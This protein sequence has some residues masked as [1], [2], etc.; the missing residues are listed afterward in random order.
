MGKLYLLTGDIIE[1]AEG[2]DAIVNAQNKHMANGSGICGAIYRNAGVELLEYCQRTY[3][4][5]MEPCEVRVTPGFNLNMNIIHSYAPIFSEWDNPID[6]LIEAYSNVLN[7]I[8]NH[9][10]KKVIIPSLG[11][12]IH[13]YNHEDVAHSVISLLYK[14]CERNDVD[15]YFINRFSIA[16]NEYLIALLELQT[17]DEKYI[18]A[19]LLNEEECFDQFVDGKELEDMCYYEQLIYKKVTE[20]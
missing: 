19:M 16:T 20:K 4:D 10:Y 1:N 6:K 9:D 2:M 11:T 17:F 3:L 8:N 18:L 14:F 7:E 12:G 5:P 13:G 15:I